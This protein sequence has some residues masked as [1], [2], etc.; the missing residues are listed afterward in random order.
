MKASNAV[1]NEGMF[2][3]LTEDAKIKLLYLLQKGLDLDLAFILL[4]QESGE[5]IYD[6]PAKADL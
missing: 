3:A 6:L 2:W 1:L 5:T 4:E